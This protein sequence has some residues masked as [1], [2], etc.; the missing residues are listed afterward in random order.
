MAGRLGGLSGSVHSGYRT[1]DVRQVTP[2]P[3]GRYEVLMTDGNRFVV[4]QIRITE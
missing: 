3:N 4:D 2:L 1:S